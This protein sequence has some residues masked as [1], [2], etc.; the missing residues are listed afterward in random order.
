[1]SA[2]RPA[3]KPWTP[4]TVEEYRNYLAPSLR[5][6]IPYHEIMQLVALRLGVEVTEHL[7]LHVSGVCTSVV[8]DLGEW[9]TVEGFRFTRWRTR[10]SPFGTRERQALHE[11]LY[12][13]DAARLIVEYATREWNGED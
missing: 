13:P 7:D 12:S 2:L 11:A 3:D 8:D 10:T 4:T 5:G 1:M 6:V 9:R